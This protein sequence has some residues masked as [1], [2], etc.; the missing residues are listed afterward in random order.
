MTEKEYK[1]YI[2][3]KAKTVKTKK[4]LDALLKEIIAPNSEANDYGNICYAM[5]AAMEATLRYINNSPNGGIT[6]FQASMIGWEM[7]MKL[8]IHSENKCG[9]KLV[10]YENML[11]PQYKEKFEKTIDKDT[12]K[13]LQEEA[14]KKLEEIKTA[15]PKVIKH[16]KKIVKGKVPFG[17]KVK[18]CGH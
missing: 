9:L 4:E 10:D 5:A 15:H 8:L 6:G 11:Y 13:A 1:N 16:W 7:V 17:Y 12:W 3:E 18:E 14:K 2:Y